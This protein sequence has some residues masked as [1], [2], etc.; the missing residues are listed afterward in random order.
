M[1]AAYVADAFRRF[2]LQPGGDSGTFV[3]RYRLA[4]LQVDTTSTVT[5]AGPGV[6]SHWTMGQ[7]VAPGAPLPL[8]D[9]TV[10]APVVLLVGMPAD[11]AQPFGDV[12]VRGT[13]ILHV[14]PR[15]LVTRGD[16]LRPLIAKGVAAGVRGWIVM[17]RVQQ[18]FLSLQ[19]Q[20]ALVPRYVTLPL[21]VD[22]G[23][24]PVPVLLVRDSSAA[25]VLRAAG[26]DPVALRDSTA[27]GVRPLAGFTATLRTR[28]HVLEGTTAP[29]VVGILPGSDS[30]L[31]E[32]YIVF[33]AHTD[34]IGAQGAGSCTAVGADSVCNGADDD[35]SGTAGL[36]ALAEAFSTLQPRPRRSL[37]F[38]AV[39]GNERGLWGSASYS[40]RQP[41]LLRQ[42]VAALNL[43][44]IGRNGRDSI[45]AVG[46]GHST[47]GE[48]ANRAS[49]QHP[50]LG[51]RVTDGGWPTDDGA[52]RSDQETFA[53]RGVPSLGFFDGAH[54]DYHKPTDSPETID[55]EKLAQ[56]VRLVFYI[57]LDV[58]NAAGR[59]QWSP[60]SRGRIVD[61]PPP[62][63]RRGPP[64]GH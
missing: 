42:T 43:D 5:I 51:L 13:I 15:S 16:L 41:G 40:S 36:V 63:P 48:V 11:T 58:A 26:E 22:Q 10:S 28:P 37:V 18:R 50:E 61:D 44:M 53:R 38:L 62:S 59:P 39:S 64:G 24:I 27:R 29:N 56:V 17:L 45:A 47:L 3:Q 9:S 19:V 30:R 33:S 14:W 52:G 34:H 32:E 2:G 8:G 4:R 49:R 23:A 31:R 12:D 20:S 6:T 25:P 60:G 46:L 57:G 21:P 54:P 35:A 55:A 1:T 7:D